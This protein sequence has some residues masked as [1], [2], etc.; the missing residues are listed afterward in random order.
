MRLLVLLIIILIV[1]IGPFLLLYGLSLLGV[2]VTYS[3]SQWLG[4]FIDRKS[5]V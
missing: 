1:V 5:V 3:F 4:A 2:P